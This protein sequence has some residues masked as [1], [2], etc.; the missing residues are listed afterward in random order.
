MTQQITD[1][2]KSK[3]SLDA[4]NALKKTG[5]T[6]SIKTCLNKNV[7]DKVKFLTR[8]FNEFR[9]EHGLISTIDCVPDARCP[10]IRFSVLN[11][12]KG[13]HRLILLKSIFQI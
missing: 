12:I 6:L 9:K 3:V 11:A 10:V 13:K 5:L 7:L 8:I 4:F 1:L 2:H